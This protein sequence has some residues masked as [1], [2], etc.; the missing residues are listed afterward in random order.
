MIDQFKL[1]VDLKNKLAKIANS[2]LEISFNSAG[3]A[4]SLKYKDIELLKN[5]NGEPNDPDKN[6]SFYCDYHMDGKTVN[7]N[8]DKLEILEDSSKRKH[9]AY[10]DNTGKLGLAYHIIVNVNDSGIYSYVKAWNNYS[11]VFP[12][13]ELRTVYRVDQSLFPIGFNGVRTGLQPSS[14][15][16]M[17]GQKVQDETYIMKDGSLYDSS[18][19][20]SKYD[21]AGYLKDTDFWGQYGDKLGIWLVVPDKSAYG[22]GPLNQD[23]MVHYDG[24]TLNYLDSEHF[25]KDLFYIPKD[26]HKTYGPWA[27]YLNDGNKDDVYSRSKNELTQWPYDWVDESDYK[28]ELFSLGGKIE[29]EYRAYDYTVIVTDTNNGEEPIN[30]QKSGYIYYSSTNENGF[31]EVTNIRAGHY[32]VYAYANISE[33]LELHFLEEIDISND[34]LLG[35]F[36]IKRDSDSIWQIGEG[37]HT[38][39]G[40][41]FSHELRNYNWQGLVPDN[42]DYYIGKSTD[43]YY[44]QNDLGRWNIHFTKN[45]L[46]TSKQIELQ[47]A[48]AGVTQKNMKD[49]QGT[50]VSL[51]LNNKSLA[52]K[53]F[54]NDRAAYR[55]AMKSGA[56]HLWK[57]SIPVD[58]IE[59]NNIISITTNGY[60][61]YDSIKLLQK[62]EGNNNG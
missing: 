61:M 11:E 53:Y 21:Y 5:L 17:T 50:L 33:D 3:K 48:F 60:V 54:S 39:D 47:L 55:S 14:K 36:R 20:Y 9:I 16:M 59:S 38:T 44:L 32:W 12:I 37:T 15:H 35:S 34:A 23:L 31:F 49:T 13:N 4:D 28:H 56:Y 22:C 52:N 41:K 6:N 42:L 51:K 7:L 62:K 46:D 57:V 24:I 26:W 29:S 19:I 27:I 18:M 2:K 30:K 25:G 10:V 45:K 40:F 1:E 43:W 58:E 8:P